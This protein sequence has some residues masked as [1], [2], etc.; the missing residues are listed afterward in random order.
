MPDALSQTPQAPSPQLHAVGGG[1]SLRAAAMAAFVSRNAMR[2]GLLGAI[3][4]VLGV[5]GGLALASVIASSA[6]DATSGG[7]APSSSVPYATLAGIV[8]IVGLLGL[9]PAL[10]AWTG[11][12]EKFGVMTMATGGAQMLLVMLLAFVLGSSLDGAAKKALVLGSFAGAF[13]AMMLQALAASYYL[14][15]P[16]SAAATAPTTS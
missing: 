4:T 15:Q 5:G 6:A 8:I 16:V 11:K 9:V 12:G 7:T 14:N 1:L 2:I 13:L 10:L 3:A